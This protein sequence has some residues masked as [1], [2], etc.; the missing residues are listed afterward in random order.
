MKN[1]PS[2]FACSLGSL[3]WIFQ[4]F[5][6][7]ACHA[8]E[9]RALADLRGT[10]GQ[11]NKHALLRRPCILHLCLRHRWH[12]DHVG[13]TLKY[14]GVRV[15]LFEMKRRSTSTTL[16][17]PWVGRFSVARI[18]DRLLMLL[19]ATR[20]LHATQSHVLLE[21]SNIAIGDLGSA[22]TDLGSSSPTE[23]KRGSSQAVVGLCLERS[24]S[25]CSH[26]QSRSLHSLV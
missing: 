6:D 15:G 2:I 18:T 22:S 12:I 25:E 9:G 24:R 17:V 4:H 5:S 3:F 23:R 1:I 26:H 21:C 19:Q 11:K 7:D 13:N 10:Q 16:M 20:L 8:A 14:S